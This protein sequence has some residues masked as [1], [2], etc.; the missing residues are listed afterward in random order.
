ML[1][2]HLEKYHCQ[3]YIN[4]ENQQHQL[5]TG[6]PLLKLNNQSKHSIYFNNSYQLIDD[7]Y[8]LQLMEIDAHLNLWTN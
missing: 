3:N 8:S 7:L 5:L 2:K 1:R 6:K 4:K